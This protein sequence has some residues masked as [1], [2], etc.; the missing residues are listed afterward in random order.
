MDGVGGVAD[1][2]DGRGSL[3]N[4]WRVVFGHGD[5]VGVAVVLAVVVV[6]VVVDALSGC[7]RKSWGTFPFHRICT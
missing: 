5:G 4:C 7:T 3:L 1:I 2:G 6:V